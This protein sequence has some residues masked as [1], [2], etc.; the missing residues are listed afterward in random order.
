MRIFVVDASA[1]KLTFKLEINEM[2]TKGV[3]CVSSEPTFRFL[4]DKQLK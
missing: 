3:F 1:G 4:C 2:L